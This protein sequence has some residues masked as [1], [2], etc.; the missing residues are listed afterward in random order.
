MIRF[1]NYSS[2]FMRCR[3][4]SS[5]QY[6]IRFDF[7]NNIVKL[8]INS[9]LRIL[10]EQWKWHQLRICNAYSQCVRHKYRGSGVYS[11]DN[12]NNFIAGY[13]LCR[14]SFYCIWIKIG[15]TSYQQIVGRTRKEKWNKKNCHKITEKTTI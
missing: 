5:L 9:Y 6:I 2:D 13:G 10:E 14:I 8:L 11:R 15:E 12:T 4:R 7:I 3:F 1:I